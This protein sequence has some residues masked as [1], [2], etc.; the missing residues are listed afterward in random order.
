[1]RTP[2]GVFDTAPIAGQRMIPRNYGTAPALLWIDL[3]LK[4]GFLL[5]PRPKGTEIAG[6]TTGSAASPGS[7]NNGRS[8]R[9]WDLQLSID[10]QN[11]TNHNNPGVPVGV[12]TSRYFGHSLSL[13]NDFSP[14]TASN[15]TVELGASFSF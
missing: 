12:L 15:R 4:R 7:A 14:L 9:P 8:D 11:L 5:G 3:Q 13:A 1:M 2:Y 6:T 10:V